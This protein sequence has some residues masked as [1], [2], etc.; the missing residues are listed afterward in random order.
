MNS[1]FKLIITTVSL[2]GFLFGFDMAV[3]SGAIPLI[4]HSF[5]LSPTQEGVFVSSALVGCIVGVL[6]AGSAS[7]RFGRRPTLIVAAILFLISAIGCAYSFSFPLLLSSRWIGGIGVGIASI[8]VPLYIAEI[9]P[10]RYRGRTVTI[11]QLAITIGILAAYLSNASI[12]TFNLPFLSDYWRM[13]FLIGSLPAILLC[14]GLF[15][16]PESPR[17]Y[18]S[19]GRMSDAQAVYHNLQIESPVLAPEIN[20]ENNASLFAP[21]YR[22]AFLIG[23]LLPLFSQLS[24]INAIVYFGPSILLESGLSMDSSLQAQVFFG[25]A[26]V[27]FTCFAIW[28]VDTWGRRPL[29]IVG[30]VGAT[31][32]LLATGWF[33]E[34]NPQAYSLLLM[35]SILAFLFCFACSIGPLKFV[36]ASEIFPSA[37]RARAMM[38]SILVMWIADTLVGQLTPILLDQWGASWTFRFFAGCCAV[39]FITVYFLLPETKG[40]QLEEMEK[41]WRDDFE[42]RNNPRPS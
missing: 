4:K 1:L 12:L 36:V 28:K 15:F 38:I 5:A 32:S 2:G 18:I 11:Y 35:C 34:L 21:R 7:D 39:A 30:T 10:S 25:V 19:R 41:Y 24:G 27:L 23:L 13:M 6:F 17:W 33:L 14:L 29:Y 9:S 40:K 42:Q 20:V 37:I 16:V 8:V 22:K 3:I 26:N 31:V